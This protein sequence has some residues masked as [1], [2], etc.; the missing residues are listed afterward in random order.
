MTTTSTLAD[1]AIA[2]PAASR[3]FQRVGL[4]YCCGG[5]KA[6]AEA[7]ASKGL[8]ADAILSAITAEEA[9]ADLPHWGTAPLSE[10]IHF[11]VERYHEPL[12]AELP[13]LISQA[14]RVEHRHAN[15]AGCPRG[16]R[17]LLECMHERVLEHLEKEER[18]LFPM[19]LDRFGKRA[20]GP[21]RVL[22]EE[23]D[24]HGRN[25]GRIR[26]F[27]NNFTPPPLACATWRALYLRLAALES[28]LM[29][30][31]HLENNVLFPRALQGREFQS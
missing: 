12:R 18:V 6:L 26:Q 24:E 25:L 17:D 8:D 22:E 13:A 19:I 16:L 31:I 14:A 5:R 23:H 7:C 28:E 15:T 30:H 21:V 2:H 3:V 9:R 10:L 27:T 11:I 29:D 1:L 4:D 20:A